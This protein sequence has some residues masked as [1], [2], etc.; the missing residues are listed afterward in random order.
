MPSNVDDNDQ[1]TVPI[2]VVPFPYFCVS[3]SA[4]MLNHLP[5]NPNAHYMLATKLYKIISIIVHAI[6]QTIDFQAVLEIKYNNIL[7]KIYRSMEN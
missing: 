4:L 7:A 6:Y 3:S 1:I 2:T 5:Q